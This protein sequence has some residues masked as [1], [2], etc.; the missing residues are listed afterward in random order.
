MSAIRLFVLVEALI[1]AG[2]GPM[3]EVAGSP[4]VRADSSRYAVAITMDYVARDIEREAFKCISEA[5]GRE[6]PNVRIVPPEDFRRAVFPDLPPEGAIHKP[7]YLALALN[8]KLVRERIGFLG[9]RYLIAIS[10]VTEQKTVGVGSGA[11]ASLLVWDRNTR[12]AASILDL[13]RE[14]ETQELTASAS[15][16]PWLLIVGGVPLYVPA[17]T[18]STV[19]KELGAAVVRFLSENSKA[20]ESGR[21]TL[22]GMHGAKS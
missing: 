9:L 21:L 5:V 20:P 15:G 18:E 19:C 8:Q 1:L 14:Q 12:L 11:P 22:L 6:F 13:S 16:Y 10:G 7:E 2:C 17:D 4:V 3:N